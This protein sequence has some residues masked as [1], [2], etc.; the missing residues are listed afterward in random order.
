MD[1]EEI[2]FFGGTK[3]K[4]KKKKKE[5]PSPQQPARSNRNISLS[6]RTLIRQKK[7]KSLIDPTRYPSIEARTIT[8]LNRH[9]SQRI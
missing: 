6:R 7:K 5:T 9:I 1:I 8:F 4:K 3:K 2:H